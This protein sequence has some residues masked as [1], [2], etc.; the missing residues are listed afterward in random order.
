MHQAA[1]SCARKKSEKLHTAFARQLAGEQ[2]V[3]AK[4][5]A[6]EIILPQARR[7]FSGLEAGAGEVAGSSGGT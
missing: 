3:V 6:D 5:R 2:D 4:F 7:Q 1:F